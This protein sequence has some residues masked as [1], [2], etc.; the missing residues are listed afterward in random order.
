M[1]KSTTKTDPKTEV[2]ADAALERLARLIRLKTESFT[3][4]ERFDRDV[5]IRVEPLLKELYPRAFEQFE[6]IPMGELALLFRWEGTHPDLTP[7]LYLAHYDVVGARAEEWTHPPYAGVIEEGILWGRGCLD[8]KGQLAGMLEAAESLAARGSRPERTCYFAFGGDEEVAGA[9]GASV[10]ARWME[11]Q[12]LSFRYILDEG[13]VITPDQMAGF[14]DAPVAL[15]GVAEKGMV[16]LKLSCRGESGHSS[17]PPAHT[18][19]GRLARA[20]TTL[21]NHPFPVRLDRSMKGLL[22]ALAPRC[23]QPL[24]G[25][26]KAQAVTKPLILKG[27]TKTPTTASLIRTTQAATLINGGT[28]ENVLPDRA[29]GVVNYRILP[30]ETIGTVKARVESLLAGQGI[31]VEVFGG[32][33]PNDPIPAPPKETEEFSRL[34]AAVEE[35]FPGIAPVPFLVN[36]STDSKY[37]RNLSDNIFRFSPVVVSREALTGVHG[38]D[39]RIS[40]ENYAAMVKFYK[41][42]LEGI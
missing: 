30:G 39:E 31:E 25:L 11:E 40:R 24:K 21:E 6:A 14:T 12:G 10:M 15:I 16:S 29:E 19:I 7:D 27:F 32:W 37:Y 41:R 28:R 23:R 13:G 35:C 17:M 26:L 33:P 3:E 34:C 4:Y 9:K 20:V 38:V 8:C 42:L 18:A 1:K 36:G 22:K 2:P 5:F